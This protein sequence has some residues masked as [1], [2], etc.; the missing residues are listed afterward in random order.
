M[1]TIDWTTYQHA[2]SLQGYVMP[3][4]EDLVAQSGETATFYVPHG[5]ARLCL[6]R[7]DGS[8]QIRLGVQPGEV[9]PMDGSA[10]AQ[11]LRRYFRGRRE[12]RLVMGSYCTARAS[13]TGILR[14]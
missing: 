6:F 1:G 7:V 11:V 14:L 9:R 2:F 10:I 13:R 8:S 5:E 3:V 12:T 4:L